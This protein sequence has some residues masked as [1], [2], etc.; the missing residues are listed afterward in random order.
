MT[1]ITGP[2]AGAMVAAA[3][4]ASAVR[5]AVAALLGLVIAV[6]LGVPANRIAWSALASKEMKEGNATLVYMVMPLVSWLL[7]GAVAT[8]IGFWLS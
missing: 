7:V 8:G 2:A 3:E 6:A 4:Q 5:V 1:I